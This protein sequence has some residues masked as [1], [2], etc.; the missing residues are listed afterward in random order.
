[1]NKTLLLSII[2]CALL[3]GDAG[4][5]KPLSAELVMSG[6]RVWEGKILSR[7]GKWIEFV[8]GTSTRPIR[9]GVSTIESLNFDVDVDEDKIS[10]LMAQRKFEKVID[11][12][13][14]M[15]EPF[16]VYKDIPSNLTRYEAA[17]MELYY[18]AKQYEKSLA[19]ADRIVG[20]DRDP[21]LQMK[22]RIYQT[23]ASI[24]SGDVDT[25]EALMVKY[26]WNQESTRDTAPEK[27]YIK[28][29]LMMLK[30]E[31]RQALL[32]AAKVVVFHSQDPD[33][34]QPSEL[35]CAELYSA[36]GM[37]DSAEEVCRQILLMYRNTPEFDEAQELMEKIEKLR[38][39][40]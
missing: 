36:L 13:N 24:D 30:G 2:A 6:D 34:M 9:V 23:L 18:Y 25:A 31:Y 7:D 10:E 38:A 35:L 5:A 4:F 3:V 28:A 40:Q 15:L 8:R 17:L 14:A 16:A 29:K 39:E 12:V 33:W 32:E 26:G 22:A 20:D 19:V 37:Y 21:A 27:L 11:I 1:M